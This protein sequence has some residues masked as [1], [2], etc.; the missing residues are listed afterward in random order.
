MKYLFLLFI[1]FNLAH[2]TR[3]Q[4]LEHTYNP[5]LYLGAPKNDLIS[6]ATEAAKNYYE[7]KYR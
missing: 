7:K 4:S 6:F 1:V 3:A 2:N 5:F